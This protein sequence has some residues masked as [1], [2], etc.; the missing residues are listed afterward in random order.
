MK[1]LVAKAEKIEFG[2]CYVT[3]KAHCGSDDMIVYLGLE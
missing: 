3:A 2:Y 1:T